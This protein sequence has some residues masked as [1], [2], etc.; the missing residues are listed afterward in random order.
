MCTITTQ[1]GVEIFF[2]DWGPRNAQPIV[3]HHGWPLSGAHTYCT[4]Y[5]IGKEY[6]KPCLDARHDI[7]E[8]MRALLDFRLH[9]AEVFTQDVPTVVAK[10]GFLQWLR[11]RA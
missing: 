2:K 3:F 10:K 8:A 1:D 6:L 9:A 11:R 7:N 5:R 4:V